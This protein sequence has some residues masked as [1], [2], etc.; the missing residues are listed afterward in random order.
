MPRI[1][2]QAVVCFFTV[3]AVA[4][5]QQTHV[6]PGRV[7]MV[8]VANT[9]DGFALAADGVSTNADGTLSTVQKLLPAGKNGAVLFAGA[10]S[11]QDPVGRPVREEV[12]VAR[13]AAA[14]LD[15][16]RDATIQAADTEINAAVSQ[17]VTK[18]F[19]T[20]N[21]G[22]ESGGY[23]FAIVFAGFAES[24][25]IVSVTRYFIPVAKGKAPRTAHASYFPKAGDAWILGGSRQSWKLTG[26]SMQDKLSSFDAILKTAE[27][28]SGKTA[29]ARTAVTPPNRFAT[30][31]VKDGFA[32]VNR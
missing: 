25:P 13:I 7:G 3:A 19:S 32:T 29:R 12:N 30:I 2:L 10:V 18:F 15:A 5:A 26:S 4:R 20:R 31:T 17:A 1:F 9:S 23:R 6:T 16:H 21:P 8:M 24:K 28:H 11:I 22:A 27:E 14:W